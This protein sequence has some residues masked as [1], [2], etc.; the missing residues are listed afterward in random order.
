MEKTVGI[1]QRISINVID[2]AN[3]EY[4]GVNRINK[5]KSIIG[6]LTQ[7]NP[8]YPYIEEHKRDYLA[9]IRYPSNRAIIY[10]ALINATYSFGY[11][12]MT[13]LGKYFHVQ[14]EVSSALIISRSHPCMPVIALYSTDCIVSYPCILRLGLLADRKWGSILKTKWKSSLRSL[15]N[16]MLNHSS[17]IIPFL[18]K[19]IMI[20]QSIHILNS[21]KNVK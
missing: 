17:S 14:D 7:R 5:A 21:Y 3:G 6:K 12:V 13:I 9:A 19:V 10:A 2:I 20:I 18:S 15:L 8:I 1:N 16:Y 11:D 4:K